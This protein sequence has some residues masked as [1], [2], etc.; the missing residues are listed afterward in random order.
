MQLKSAMML[1]TLIN[2]YHQGAPESLLKGLSPEESLDVQQKVTASSDVAA[3]M[4]LMNDLEG[5]RVHYSWL[6]PTIESFSS[7]MQPLLISALPKTQAVAICKLMEKLDLPPPSP[8][9][10]KFL[11]GLLYRK[12]DH[13]SILPLTFLPKS[14]L[15]PLTT[16]N[17]NQMI[18]LIDFLGL[19]DLAEEIKHIVEKVKLKS[20]YAC[21]SPKQ[22]VFLKICLH[23]KEKLKAER[24]DLSNWKGDSA[25]LERVLHRRGILRL[26]YAL[27]GQ[28][29]DFVWHI[30]HRLDVGRGRLLGKYFSS[31]EIQGV[32]QLLI[33]QSLNTLNYLKKASQ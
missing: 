20:I 5:E 1:R 26:S 22:Q 30:I 33:Q 23:Q 19:Y 16:L 21:L 17:K 6:V 14:N 15:D 2:R 7:L 8:P 28:P 10:K 27:A 12:F 31:K 3:V 25:Q 13:R 24:M 4:A 9:V 11:L 32:T 29:R 18:E